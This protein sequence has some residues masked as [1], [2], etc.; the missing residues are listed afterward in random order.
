M[1]NNVHMIPY[2]QNWLKYMHQA[3]FCP[4]ITT[5]IAVA[6]NGFLHSFLLM[7]QDLIS[8]HLI[9]NPATAKGWMKKTKA[10]ICSTRQPPPHIQKPLRVDMHNIMSKGQYILT[11]Q[12]PYQLDPMMVTN[13]SSQHMPSMIQTTF[14]PSLSNPAQ[15]TTPLLNLAQSS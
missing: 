12:V 3:L 10:G 11:L 1:A 14:M 5:P 2:L 4:P 7:T 13:T 6:N 8:M 9:K 15:M